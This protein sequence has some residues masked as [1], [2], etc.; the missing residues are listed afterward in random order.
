MLLPQGTIFAIIDGETFELY[1]NSGMERDPEL[2]PLETPDLDTTNYSSGVKD[3]DRVSRF[4][5][6]APKD[7]LDKLEERAHATAVIDWLNQQVLS[8]GIDKLIIIADPRSL[9]EMRRHYHK[10]LKKVLLGELD[11]TLTGRPPAE[12]VKALRA[13]A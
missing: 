7:R 6:G 3:H 2:E 8:G 5:T 1:R 4:T 11:R 10:E 9:G 13:T 12:I